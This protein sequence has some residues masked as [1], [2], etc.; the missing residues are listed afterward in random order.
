MNAMS[1]IV[2][3]ILFMSIFTMFVVP[4]EDGTFPA[5]LDDDLI[6][7]ILIVLMVVCVL[8]LI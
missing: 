2:I 1:V 4:M 7:L 3:I 5:W 8:V 6:Q